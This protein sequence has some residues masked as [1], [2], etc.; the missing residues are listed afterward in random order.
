MIISFSGIDGS[1]KTTQINCLKDYCNKNKI[2]Y[3]SKWSKARGTPGIEFL[4]S[5]VRKDK[6]FNQE[7]K[8]MYREEVYGSKWKKNTL[9]IFSMLDLCWYWG[10][11]FRILNYKHKLVILDR[12]I[13][14]TYVE[15]SSEFQIINLN[16][17]LLW[18]LVI[19]FA[20]KPDVSILLLIPAEES[21]NRDLQK[22]EI[23]TDVIEIK[24]A[25]INYYL[26]LKNLSCWNTVLNSMKNIEETHNEILH[27][28]NLKNN[29]L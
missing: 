28:L 21:F 24:Q 14:D 3:I 4:K 10:I 6:V 16:K 2:N 20:V 29:L 18:K 9:F 12:Y 22:K 8:L 25:K 19:F 23:T 15:V 7:Q 5:C 26:Y 13:W 27:K 11:Y 17:S 1:G